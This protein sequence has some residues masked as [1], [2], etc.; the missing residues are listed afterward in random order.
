M[1]TYYNVVV[2]ANGFTEVYEDDIPTVELARAHQLIL[3]ERYNR[4][5]FSEEHENWTA[6]KIQKV[7]TEIVE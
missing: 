6:F 4:G 1:K 5:I 3:S 7:V 2:F